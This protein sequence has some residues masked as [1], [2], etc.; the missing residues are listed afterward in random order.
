MRLDHAQLLLVGLDAVA[1]APAK[2][3]DLQ[4]AATR[5]VDVRVANVALIDN[6]RVV[7]W[8]GLAGRNERERVVQVLR[9]LDDA[10]DA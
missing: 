10:Y 3:L 7:D 6:A 2:D 5:Q 1:E 8:V 4:R 9:V